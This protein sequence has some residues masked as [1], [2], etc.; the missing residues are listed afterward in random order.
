MTLLSIMNFLSL[1][2]I[3]HS[4]ILVQLQVE[5]QSYYLKRDINMKKIKIFLAS[6]LNEL[7]EQ[8]NELA[9]FILG[10]SSD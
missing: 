7:S 5:T 2:A 8:R 6:A 1:Q 9:R 10:Q 3:R 4:Y